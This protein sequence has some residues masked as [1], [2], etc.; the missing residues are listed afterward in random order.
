MSKGICTRPTDAKK[1]ELDFVVE[2]NLQ[3]GPNFFVSNVSC[4]PGF[5][6]AS[7]VEVKTCSSHQDEYTVTGCTQGILRPTSP[8][9]RHSKHI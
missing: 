9:P 1:Y 4:A 5:W 8:D 2:E 6:S 3:M 7:A